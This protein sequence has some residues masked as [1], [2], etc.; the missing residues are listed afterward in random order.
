MMRFITFFCFCSCVLLTNCNEGNV[1][2]VIKETQEQ[3]DARTIYQKDIEALRYTEFGLSS[4]SQ[5]AVTD[6]QKFQELNTQI[7]LLKKGDLNFFNGDRVLLKTFL[8]EFRT[9]MPT[10]LKTNEILARITAFETKTQ[11]LN[12]LLTISNISKKEQ[13]QGIKELLVTISNL[14]LQINKK[15]EFDKN[16]ILKPE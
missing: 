8:L 2:E 16:N 10:Q 11:K 6:W 15:F 14:N 3:I 5:K 1:S 7:E 12:S 4:D 13:L 9:E